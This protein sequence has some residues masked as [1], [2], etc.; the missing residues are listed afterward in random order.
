MPENVFFASIRP[1]PA[2]LMVGQQPL[3]LFIGVRVPGRQQ[4]NAQ[5]F[6][7]RSGQG[8]EGNRRGTR[9]YAGRRFQAR[10]ERRATAMSELLGDALAGSK[11]LS[12]KSRRN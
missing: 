12:E 8:L 4:K 10:E 7:G 3:K 9:E 11:F 2:R 6:F 5:Q 1:L